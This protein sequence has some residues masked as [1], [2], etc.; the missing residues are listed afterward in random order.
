MEKSCSNCTHMLTFIGVD[1]CDRLGIL[2]P[3]PISIEI[4]TPLRNHLI[5]TCGENRVFW[6]AKSRTEGVVH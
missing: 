5:V 1:M 6:E 3:R 2:K 4:R